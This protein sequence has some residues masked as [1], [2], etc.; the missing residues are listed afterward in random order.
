MAEDIKTAAAFS[1]SWNNLPR[2]SVYSKA[3]FE[4]W[5][6]P[7]SNKDIEGKKVLELGCGNGSLMIHLLDWHPESLLGIDLGDSVKSASGCLDFSAPWIV[8]SSRSVKFI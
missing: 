7:L 8:L 2:G 1:N 4:D 6:H 3:Q 5:F